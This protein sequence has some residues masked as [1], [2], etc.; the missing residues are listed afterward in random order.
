[1]WSTVCFGIDHSLVLVG[2][3]ILQKRGDH[4]TTTINYFI[5]HGKVLEYKS[6]ELKHSTLKFR[7]VVLNFKHV[8]FPK[9]PYIFT[10]FESETNFK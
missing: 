9:N 3:K 8:Y 7:R 10:I 1:M 2:P 6:S 5:V 4:A